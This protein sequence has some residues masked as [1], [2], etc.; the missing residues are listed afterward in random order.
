MIKL[1][2]SISDARKYLIAFYS[3]RMKK[4]GRLTGIDKESLTI[5]ME[6]ESLEL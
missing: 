3:R 4:A 2:K 6:M 5:Y 1:Y